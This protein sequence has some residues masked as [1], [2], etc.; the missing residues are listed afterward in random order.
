MRFLRRAFSGLFLLALTLGLLGWAGQVVW[1]AA[2]EAMAPPEP[3]GPAL[4]RVIAARV[5]RIKPGE[6]VPQMTA[7]GEVKSRRTLEV[8]APASGVV[9]DLPDGITDGAEVL[10][11]QVLLRL[12]PAE[13]LAAR[14]LAASDLATSQ[15]D[16]RSAE[17][18]IPLARDELAGAVAQ[19]DLRARA[20]ERQRALVARGAG[21]EALVQEAEL[22]QNAAAQAVLSA[23]SGL[24]LA[25]GRLD[26]ALALSERRRIAV[27][28]AER[29]LDL[30]EVRAAFGGILSGMAVSAGARVSAGEKLGQ[31]ID[32]GALE[33]SFRLSTSQFGRLL[34]QNGAL[35]MARLDIAL[36]MGGDQI[37][38]AGR[39][40]RVGAEVGQGQTGRLIYATLDAPP[41]FRPGDFVSVRIAEPALQGVAL[42]PAA[43]IGADGQVLVLGREDR[44][45]AQSVDL[46][47]R[48]G[49]A[50]I[51]TAAGLAGREVIAERTPLLGAGIK[52]EPLRDGARPKP[53]DEARADAVALS[54]ERRAELTALVEANTTMPTEAKARMLSVLQQDLVPLDVIARIEE[55]RGG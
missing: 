41:G 37:A 51:V 32:P 47:R 22:S 21:T 4:E 10:A 25:E 52:V 23:R 50:V 34:D 29:A 9:I 13:A 19:A 17:R 5:I 2:Q 43:A 42:L 49:D 33:V 26:Q 39:L 48:Q 15:A 12:D 46:V 35:I 53:A 18:A 24:A 16:A 8:R 7:F 55:R 28:Q 36:E 31:I 14:D 11:G 40:A 3:G 6:I 54:P 1:Q 27:A 45:E 30:T 44:L 38:S 20:L